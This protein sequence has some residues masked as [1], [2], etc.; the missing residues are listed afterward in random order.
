MQD[1][2]ENPK[3]SSENKELENFNEPI[4]KYPNFMDLKKKV[5]DLEINVNSI[6][7]FLKCWDLK[8]SEENQKRN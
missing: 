7:E 3:E 2:P 4:L 5:Y 8:Y 1:L 6:L